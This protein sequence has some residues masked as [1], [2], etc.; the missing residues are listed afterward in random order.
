MAGELPPSRVLLVEGV[1][2][3]H[4]VMHLRKRHQNV[5]PFHILDKGGFPSLKSS[6]RPE[7]KVSGRVALGIVTDANSTPAQRWQEIEHQLSQASVALPPRMAPGGT[8]VP[9]AP[10]VG[11]WLMPDNGSSGELEDFI[12]RMIPGTDPGWPRARRYI[13][14]IPAAERKFASNKILRAK[15]H[16]W[17]AA[18]AEP[19]KIGSAIGFGDLDATAPL[20]GE[21]IDWLRRLFN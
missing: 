9:G 12:E 7:I 1:D 13:D 18:R 5:P 3:K 15:V 8:I 20:A 4:V 6:I 14:N 2:D 19:R 17:L 21:F 10:R 11:V 16:A